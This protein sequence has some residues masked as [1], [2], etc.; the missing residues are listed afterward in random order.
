MQHLQHIWMIYANDLPQQDHL[1]IL[2]SLCLFY[3]RDLHQEN[4]N[5]ESFLEA[6]I[7]CL[8]KMNKL[9]MEFQ[10]NIA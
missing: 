3:Q 9:L 1:H 10:Q 7:S 5:N 2:W 4:P 6:F 8:M